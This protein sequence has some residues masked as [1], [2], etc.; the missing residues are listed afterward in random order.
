MKKIITLFAALS[1]VLILF[2][3]NV[4][5]Q[6]KQKSLLSIHLGV[7]LPV[8]VY[9]S[10]DQNDREAGYAQSGFSGSLKFTKMLSEKFGICI[11]T[12]SE[13]NSLNTSALQT[14]VQEQAPGGVYVSVSGDSWSTGSLLFGGDFQTPLSVSSKSVF[15]VSLMLGYMGTTSP[16]INI[17]LSGLGTGYINYPAQHAGA[18]ALAVGA[19]FYLSVSDKISIPITIDYLSGTPHFSSYTAYSSAGPFINDAYDQ[20]VSNFNLMTGI[21]IQLN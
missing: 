1:T 5:A 14:Q 4:K 12:H 17:A 3:L 2:A 8:G 16:A 15:D 11:A 19:G 21:V 20:P 7:A 6:E 10:T 9:S 13:I 18:F